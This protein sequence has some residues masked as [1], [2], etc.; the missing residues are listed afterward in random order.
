LFKQNDDDDDTDDTDDTDDDDT[1]DND[2]DDDVDDVYDDDVDDDEDVDDDDDDVD[3]VGDDDA[4]KDGSICMLDQL[5]LVVLPVDPLFSSSL[6]R[7]LFQSKLFGSTAAEPLTLLFLPQP[8]NDTTSESV[9]SRL[10]K[11]A[12]RSL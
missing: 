9:R 6:D 2:D 3:D 4:D 10:N 11:Q 7:L 1:D 5:L 8:V 12:Q